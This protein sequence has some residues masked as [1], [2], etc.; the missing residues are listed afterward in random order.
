MS[1]ALNPFLLANL[2]AA[3][4]VVVVLALRLPARRLFG[5]R[6][7]YG[8]WL[9]VPMA[10][11]A[12]LLPARVETV[13]VAAMSEVAEPIMR[14]STT[15]PAVALAVAVDLGPLLLAL[16]LGGAALS[17]GWL[18]WRQAQFGR[19]VREG[20][21]GPAVVGVLKPRIVTPDDFDHRYT[22]RE[23]FVVLAHEETHIARHDSRINALVAAARCVN[24]FN[25]L[26]HV[27]ARCLRMDQELACDA[28]VVAAHPTARRSYAEAM[29]KAQL[30]ARP[31]P[32]GCY[33]LAEAPHP[34]AERIRLLSRCTPG[35]AQ[36][37]L[38]VAVLAL[39]AAAAIGATWA[40]KPAQVTFVQTPTP[41]LALPGALTAPAPATP[42]PIHQVRSVTGAPP[43][44]TTPAEPPADP[45]IAMTQAQVDADAA[46]MLAETDG[47]RGAVERPPHVPRLPRERRIYA[48]ANRSSVEPGSAVR[49]VASA[50]DREGRALMADLTSFGS[51]HYYRTGSYVT[52]GSKQAVF[53]AVVQRGDRLWVT[54]SLNRRFEGDEV[55]TIE[56]RSGE[57]RNIALPNGQVVTV[58]P[59]LR[60]ET[61]EEAAG[62][63]EALRRV[64]VD[65][66]RSSREAWE[67]LRRR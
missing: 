29:L 43:P 62:A 4:A 38:G 45:V 15:A 61:A 3:V 31:L 66:D 59:T 27:L 8:L 35:P 57:T 50:F 2:A 67:A 1:E 65:L 39:L 47:V 33:W 64:D 23:R 54:V 51:Q 13:R 44:E 10:A 22:P 40:A 58:T 36:R 55:G 46:P 63:H 34:L 56:M 41:Q 19:A 21:A 11:L 7:A 48:I 16:W 60:P 20:L 9:L 26:L 17:L 18:A 30:A 32:L 5:A 53:T 24:W 42:A 6:I 28:Q 25:P 14:A 49:V 12:T 52:S 37:A